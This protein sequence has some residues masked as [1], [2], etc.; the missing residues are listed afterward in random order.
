MTESPRSRL[1]RYLDSSNGDTDAL[2][3]LYWAGLWETYFFYYPLA[4]TVAKNKIDNPPYDQ[5]DIECWGR[6]FG[7]NVY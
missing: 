4:Y 7:K 2:T 1:V 6:Y 5:D 3:N